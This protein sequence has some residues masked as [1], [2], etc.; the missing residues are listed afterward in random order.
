CS[1]YKVTE[2]QLLTSRRGSSNEA[3]DVAIFLIRQLTREGLAPLCSE[4]NMKRHSS[5]SSAIER[6]KSRMVKDKR[7]RR[8]IEALR[9]G[10]DNR[11]T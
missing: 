5:A 8:R 3:R 1:T 6:V 7:L 10:L 11:Q 2:A 9:V 4:F